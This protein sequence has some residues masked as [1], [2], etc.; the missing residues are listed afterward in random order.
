MRLL[1]IV[2]LGTS[3]GWACK[4]EQFACDTD[5]DCRRSGELGRCE[6]T[7]YCSFPTEDCPSRRRYGDLAPIDLAGDCVDDELG[8]SSVAGSSSESG[9]SGGV[10]ETGLVEG[11]PY[12]PCTL[13]PDCAAPGATCLSN[14]DSRMCAPSCPVKASPSTAC[15][16]AVGG[17]GEVSCLYTDSG[18]TSLG[19]FI[20]CASDAQCPNGM[21]CRDPVC[22]WEQPM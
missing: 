19:C 6:V 17:G 13:T 7:N 12:G 21:V 8:G 2:A 9:S 10:A 16:A 4:P 5:V 22:T 20:T 1:V 15:P 14:G 11:D 18:M 3:L